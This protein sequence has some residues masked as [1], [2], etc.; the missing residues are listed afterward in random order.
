MGPAKR[1]SV[2][3]IRKFLSSTLSL[4]AQFPVS[5]KRDNKTFSRGESSVRIQFPIYNFNDILPSIIDPWRNIYGGGSF[6]D[7]YRTGSR[8]PVVASNVRV[9]P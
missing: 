5:I 4:G 3:E 9:T 1:L 7:I 2:N 8:L 6:T